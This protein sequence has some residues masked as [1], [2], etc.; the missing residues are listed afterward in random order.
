MLQCKAEPDVQALLQAIDSKARGGPGFRVLGQGVLQYNTEPD[1]QA[2]L[3]AIDSK[4]RGG[5]GLRALE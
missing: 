2:L 1:V 3:Q 5:L 4:A